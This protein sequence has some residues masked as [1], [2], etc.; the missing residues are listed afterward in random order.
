MDAVTSSYTTSA[1][2]FYFS[3]GLSTIVNAVYSGVTGSSLNTYTT[4]TG[5]TYGF[6]I[7]SNSTTVMTAC[8]AVG[9]THVYRLN[10]PLVITTLDYGYVGD[11]TNLISGTTIISDTD[12]EFF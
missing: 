12:V 4:T 11:L 5:N 3:G 6:Y 7:A 1:G 9:D 10:N 8:T 2:Y